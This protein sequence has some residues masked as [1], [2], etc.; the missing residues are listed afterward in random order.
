MKNAP[1]MLEIILE[2]FDR[3]EKGEV[4]SKKTYSKFKNILQETLM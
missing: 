2:F 4:R 1:K 3:V